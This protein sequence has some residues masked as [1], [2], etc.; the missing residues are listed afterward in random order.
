MSTT[1]PRFTPFIEIENAE[2]SNPL[3]AVIVRPLPPERDLS[4]ANAAEVLRPMLRM[5][6]D[7]AVALEN[8]QLTEPGDA[9]NG[10][11]DERAV[12]GKAGGSGSV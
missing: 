6:I 3:T 7:D 12:M 9:L 2:P 8:S 4:T 5:T 10:W 11:D 1:S